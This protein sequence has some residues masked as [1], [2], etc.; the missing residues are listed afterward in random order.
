[1][2]STYIV[3]ELEPKCLFRIDDYWYRLV[4]HG[5]KTSTADVVGEDRKVQLDPAQIVT[6]VSVL[7][8]DVCKV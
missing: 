4:S 2:G 1:M 7:F 3:A 5:K 8:R 6:E